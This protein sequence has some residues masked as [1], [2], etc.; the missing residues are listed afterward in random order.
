MS[1]MGMYAMEQDERENL[2]G[3]DDYEAWIVSI[4]GSYLCPYCGTISPELRT[5]CGEVHSV[6]ICDMNEE[7]INI[8]QKCL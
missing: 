5:C 7:A 3:A 1:D 8:I 6:K 4:E 2:S